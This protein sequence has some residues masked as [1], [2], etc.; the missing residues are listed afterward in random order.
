[1]YI[2]VVAIPNKMI[3]FIL[4]CALSCFLAFFTLTPVYCVLVGLLLLALYPCL[5]LQLYVKP[6]YR[7]LSF[8][9]KMLFVSNIVEQQMFEIVRVPIG[10]LIYQRVATGHLYMSTITSLCSL[11]GIL[12]SVA[13]CMANFSS[14]TTLH[15]LIMIGIS[16]Y[17]ATGNY[18]VAGV[19]YLLAQCCSDR[20]LTLGVWIFQLYRLIVV[21]MDLHG[22]VWVMCLVVLGYHVSLTHCSKD[23]HGKAE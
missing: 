4:G 21:P 14:V 9:E 19:V 22:V 18:H 13:L 8:E 6:S 20:H 2:K 3:S 1:M 16:L 5:H 11:Y 23:D 10:V 12:Y 15:H 17:T 7:T